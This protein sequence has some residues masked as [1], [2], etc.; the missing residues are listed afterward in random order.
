M[1]VAA[2]VMQ[3]DEDLLIDGWCRYHGNLFGY[4]NLY[5]FDNGS[6]NEQTIETLRKYA[7]LGANIDWSRTEVADF[8]FKGEVVGALFRDLQT[9]KRYDLFLP[10]DCDEF[11]SVSDDRSVSFGKNA[12]LEE[13]GKFIDCP[14]TVKI[15]DEFLNS[16]AYTDFFYRINLNKVMFSADNF[17]KLDHGF[18]LAGTDTEQ[19]SLSRLALI[20]FHN[21]PFARTVSDAKRKLIGL[22]VNIDDM[23]EL[24][25][26]THSMHLLKYFRMSS[27]EWLRSFDRRC[28]VKIDG[29]SQL[30]ADLG[31]VSPIFGDTANTST[32]PILFPP[33][34]D[35]EQYFAL[36]PDVADSTM[37]AERHFMIFGGAEGR[38]CP[39]R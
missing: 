36:Y 2:A 28:H 33:D 20:H 12:I 34:F 38:L 24:E 14:D 35:G 10:L 29:F 1:Q 32:P 18:H 7:R 19:W 23:E 11:V 37:T 3:K 4:E 26:L 30:M 22:G 6:T 5:V 31:V 21:K 39:R 13:M 27:D 15:R 17:R 9:S 8:F 25:N 16:P